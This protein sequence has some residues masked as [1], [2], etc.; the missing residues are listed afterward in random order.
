MRDSSALLLSMLL[1]NNLTHYIA[2]SIVTLLLLSRIEAEHTAELLATFITAPI[3]FVFAELIPKSIFF[4]RSDTLMPALA[5]VL[6][7]FHKTFSFCGAVPLLKFASRL[8]ARLAGLRSPYKTA[9]TA[10][11]APHIRVIFQETREEDIL[12]PVQADI[13]NRIVSISDV[14]ISSVMT[15]A[16]KVRMVDVNSDGPALLKTLKKYA[17][18]RLPVY[19]HRPENIIGFINIYESLSSTEQFADLRKFIKPIRKLPADTIVTEAIN[20]MQTENQK[21][22]LVTRAGHAGRERPL[23]IV[24]M[25]DLVE[26]LLGELTEW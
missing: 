11:C 25:K 1:G 20:I 2:T 5:P 19:E 4:Y 24:T 15:P 12:S 23:G 26:E 13:I 22:V 7:A 3:L 14:R 6:F 10:V 17:F 18:T 8:F 16:G 9:I 21:I